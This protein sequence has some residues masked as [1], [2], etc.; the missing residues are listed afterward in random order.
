MH[1]PRAVGRARSPPSPLT[2]QQL[3]LVFL[4]RRLLHSP[5]RTS[6][7]ARA[8]RAVGRARSLVARTRARARREPRAHPATA[9]TAATSRRL[10]REV[11]A[12]RREVRTVRVGLHSSLMSKLVSVDGF[13]AAC[14]SRLQASVAFRTR[15]TARPPSLP[16][17][18][19]SRQQATRT[20]T[21]THTHTHTQAH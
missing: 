13:I 15:T 19:H 14:A 2:R 10:G 12:S 3:L 21:H 18:S 16:F 17:P 7:Q 4:R 9:A 5:P 11:A 6:R 8:Q 1:G 20:H